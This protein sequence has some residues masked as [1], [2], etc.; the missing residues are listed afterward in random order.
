MRIS[1]IQNVE[2]INQ[3]YRKKLD[4]YKEAKEEV[5][6]LR[7]KNGELEDKLRSL[8]AQVPTQHPS[9]KEFLG[10]L[11]SDLNSER[12]ARMDRELEMN[13]LVASNKDQ[14]SQIER[15]LKLN[16]KQVE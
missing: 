8:K 5:E 7:S 3:V 10:Q 12:Q 2:A 15:L 13:K 14:E 6:R 4:S 1:E 11:K 16:N 9:V